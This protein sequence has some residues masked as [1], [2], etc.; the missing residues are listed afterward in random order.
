M[1]RSG[2]AAT[3]ARAAP[4]FCASA[5]RDCST[6]RFQTSPPQAIS[7]CRL[8]QIRKPGSDAYR[9]SRIVVG[10]L[11][12]YLGQ[13]A[14]TSESLRTH[15]RVSSNHYSRSQ[16][17]LSSRLARRSAF[18][19]MTCGPL[20]WAWV[21]HCRPRSPIRAW[22]LLRPWLWPLARI[23]TRGAAARRPRR[24]GMRQAAAPGQRLNCF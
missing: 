7:S 3:S 24:R 1:G 14:R 15:Q 2:P 17:G 13:G 6:Y 4:I 23:C 8:A 18:R 12:R 16:G 22:R 9:C 5:R 20:R 19:K 11:V 10:S 21:P